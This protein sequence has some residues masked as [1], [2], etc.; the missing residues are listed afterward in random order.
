LNDRLVHLVAADRID[1]QATMPA[2]EITA[3]SAVPP[4]MSTTMLPPAR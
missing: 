2:R 4:P 1:L 3:T